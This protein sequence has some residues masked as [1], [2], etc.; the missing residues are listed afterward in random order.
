LIEIAAVDPDRV[1]VITNAIFQAVEPAC[2]QAC[3]AIRR[4]L[5]IPADAKLIVHIGGAFYKNRRAVI[6]VFA[7]ISP[8]IPNTFLL[9]VSA[10]ATE[11]SAVISSNNLQAH[12]H[13]EP[14]I[15]P[16]E[17]S[18]LYTTA[19]LLLFPSLYEG[20]GYPVIE[21]QLCGTPVICSD[22][23]SL[24]EV[25]GDGARLFDPDDIGGMAEAAQELLS[26]EAAAATLVAHGRQN[27]RRFA[28]SQWFDA[29][30]ALYREL[31]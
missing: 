26:D 30:G 4:K 9:F 24:P 18:A 31:L 5:G 21:A 2:P 28:Q 27:V 11:L 7:R 22:A 16:A 23:G 13:F 3:S 25:A 14:Y 20:F 1:S 12:V 29:H 10:P 8:A 6:E 19:S 17:L 15:A